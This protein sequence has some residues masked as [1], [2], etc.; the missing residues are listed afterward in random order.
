MLE[1]VKVAD[2]TR[3]LTGPLAPFA[4]CCSATSAPT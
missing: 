4:P 3:V 1:G 2:F